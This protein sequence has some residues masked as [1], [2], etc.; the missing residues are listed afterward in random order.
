MHDVFLDENRFGFLSI[1]VHCLMAY[2]RLG[3]ITLSGRT[4]KFIWIFTIRI[5]ID[6]RSRFVLV[7]VHVRSSIYNTC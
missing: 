4:P 6:V 3:V 2:L 5:K 1:S 7:L